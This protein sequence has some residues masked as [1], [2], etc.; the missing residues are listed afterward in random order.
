MRIVIIV[1]M[2]GLTSFCYAQKEESKNSVEEKS[3]ELADELKKELGLSEEQYEKV[4]LIYV[5][6]T[7]QKKVLNQE[8]KQLEKQKKELKN[9]RNLKINSILTAEQKAKVEKKQNSKRRK[10]K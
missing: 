8:I 9:N 2:L 7:E 3:I 5:D 1:L 6:Y 4:R 10:K